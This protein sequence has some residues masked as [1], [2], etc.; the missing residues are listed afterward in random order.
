[1]DIEHLRAAFRCKR[2]LALRPRAASRAVLR[3]RAEG[4][5]HRRLS[6]GE[7]GSFELGGD[8]VE[9]ERGARG[10]R[11]GIHLAG[12]IWDPSGTRMTGVDIEVHAAPGGSVEIGISPSQ[13]LP[14]W[15]RERDLEHWT[16]LAR[17]ALD[18]VCEELLWHAGHDDEDTDG[19]ARAS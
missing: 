4:S 16:E 11:V 7:R 5:L 6:L 12:R 8:V 14:E 17:A 9:V 2:S 1:V 19:H 18:E 15:F 10:R 13:R 3:L